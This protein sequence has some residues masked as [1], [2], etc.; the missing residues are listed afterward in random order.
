[1]HP[2]SHGAHVWDLMCDAGRFEYG[3]V[4]HAF[5]AALRRLMQVLHSSFMR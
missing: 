5:C 4:C 2:I 3:T 1:M